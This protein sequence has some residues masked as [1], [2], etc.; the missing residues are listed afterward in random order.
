VSTPDKPGETGPRTAGFVSGPGGTTP[1]PSTPVAVTEGR[2]RTPLGSM[3]VLAFGMVALGLYLMWFAVHY[4]RSSVKWPSDPLKAVLTGA[5]PPKAD[6]AAPAS[7]QISVA[8]AT[9]GAPITAGESNS[10]YISFASTW[11]AKGVD[12]PSNNQALGQQIAANAGWTGPTWTALEQLWQAISGWSTTVT[13]KTGAYGIPGAQPPSAMAS[14]GADWQTNPATQ[15][16]WG[17]GYVKTK[18]TTPS[19]AWTYYTAHG[20]YLW[21]VR[22]I[23]P[24]WRAW[25]C[26]SPGAS[27]SASR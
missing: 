1:T 22:G 23:S 26:C 11:H 27:G 2:L 19:A 16:T 7:A 8:A 5:P 9:E 10:Q 21:M 17:V 18:Y 20:S 6:P 13:T 14:A 3:P 12:T 4:W 24:W 25:C 15:I